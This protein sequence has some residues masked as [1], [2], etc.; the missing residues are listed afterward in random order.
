MNQIKSALFLVSSFLFA[1]ACG[2][3]EQPNLE[4][5]DLLGRWELDRAWRNGKQTETLT[6][7]FYEFRDAGTMTTNLTPLLTEEN[8]SFS[9]SGDE[10]IQKGSPPVTYKVE[11]LSDTS[12][13][14]SMTI[15]NFPFRLQ[16][17]KVM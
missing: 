9:F 11:S 13:V 12:M 4:K 17:K 3:G 16:L 10:I 1:A 14:L 8:F 2:S 7:T 15:N 5:N 6:G